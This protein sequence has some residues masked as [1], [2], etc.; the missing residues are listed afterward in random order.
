MW[1]NHR[2]DLTSLSS[3]EMLNE[4]GHEF[5]LPQSPLRFP[6]FVPRPLSSRSGL[7]TAELV[8]TIGLLIAVT[9]LI[10]GTTQHDLKQA[11]LRR[12]SAALD[13]LVGVIHLELKNTPPASLPTL[14]LGPGAPPL[15][16]TDAEER[17]SQFF[18]SD[19]FFPEDPWGRAYV[20]QKV[21]GANR[22]QV[23]CAGPSG[24]LPQQSDSLSALQRELL[25]PV[26]A[27]S[28]R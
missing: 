5:G 11:K 6:L 16:L 18:S 25:P 10:L 12:A 2:P 15:P 24:H 13:Y 3:A 27:N 8:W 14:L 4:K 9:A 1:H 21:A 20:L 22:W 17:L 7:T 26:S 23:I 19:C 28:A